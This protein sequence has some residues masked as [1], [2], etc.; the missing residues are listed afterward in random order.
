M[1]IITIDGNIGSGKSTILK[2]LQSKYDQIIDLE[3]IESWKPYLDNIYLHDKFYYELHKKIWEDRGLLQS[4]S[5]NII[6]VE[7]SGKFTRNT[8][9]EIYKD[10]FTNQEYNILSHLY[11]SSDEKN[12]KL[13]TD[14]VLYIYLKTDPNLCLKRIKERN[15]DNESNINL[16]LINKLHIK[17][18][19]C[20]N[21]LILQGYQVLNIDG[22]KSIIDICKS[23]FE[24]VY[25]QI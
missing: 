17:H 10:K 21:N 24:Y 1:P 9:I 19:E 12:N 8:F 16:S 5:K 23:I 11:D 7:R 14:P 6:F 18:E 2:E 15:R 13:I 3:P 25:G 20:A 22:E 4:R